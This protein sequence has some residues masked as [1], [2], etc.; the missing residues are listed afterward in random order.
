MGNLAL[1]YQAAGKLDLALPLLEE[2]TLKLRKAKLGPEHPDT[3]RTMGDLALAYLAAAAHQAWRGQDK[4]LAATCGHALDLAKDSK[5]AGCMFTTLAGLRRKSREMISPAWRIRSRG[6]RK[7]AA[8]A[9]RG[10]PV[11]AG[12]LGPT[13]MR[14]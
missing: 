1:A 13:P 5:V 7:L 8:R 10:S 12:S 14:L 3:L 2:T 9:V 6:Y 11:W 4:E